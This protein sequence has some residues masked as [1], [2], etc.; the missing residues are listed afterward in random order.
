M[1]QYAQHWSTSHAR[2]SVVMRAPTLQQY[3]LLMQQY[4]LLSVVASCRVTV[5]IR[6]FL[7]VIEPWLL[8]GCHVICSYMNIYLLTRMI[9]SSYQVVFRYLDL[10]LTAIEP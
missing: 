1:L 3:C 2:T 5:L 9:F 4:C 6:L 7:L 8:L 10:L